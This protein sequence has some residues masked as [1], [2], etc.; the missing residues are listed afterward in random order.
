L[1]NQALIIQPVSIVTPL[2]S[3]G[4]GRAGKFGELSGES[5]GQYQ[6]EVLAGRPHGHGYY[7]IQKVR[8]HNKRLLCLSF[9][10]AVT[11]KGQFKGVCSVDI[12][13]HRASS[14]AEPAPNLCLKPGVQLLYK[15]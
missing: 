2:L 13:V 7:H 3:P 15:K 5:G 1:L 4:P 6:G 8:Q 10:L 12:M 14:R 11:F 9:L